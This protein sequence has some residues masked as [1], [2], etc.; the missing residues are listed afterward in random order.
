MSFKNFEGKLLLRVFLLLLSLSAPSIVITNGWAELLVFLVPLLLYQVYELYHFLKKAQE[1]LN[2]FI[3]A[4]QYRDFS[5]Y[6][7]EKSTSPQLL[8]LRRGFNQI[9]TTFKNINQEKETQHQH[10][11]RIL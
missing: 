6:F 9:N 10:L 11:Q 5:R 7:S 1:E 4:I 8:S 2:L 3:E